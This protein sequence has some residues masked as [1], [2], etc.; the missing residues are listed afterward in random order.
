MRGVDGDDA[1][2]SEEKAD[3]QRQVGRRAKP[4]QDD[5]RRVVRAGPTGR[6]ED[7][8]EPVGLVANPACFTRAAGTDCR[9]AR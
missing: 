4:D 9:P 3:L 8:V 2:R 1:T 6:V 7:V 5:I